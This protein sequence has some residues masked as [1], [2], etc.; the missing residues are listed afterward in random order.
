V[1]FD[2]FTP[3]FESQPDQVGKRGAG[4]VSALEDLRKVVFLD[5]DGVLNVPVVRDGKPYPPASLAELEFTPDARDATARLRERGFMLVMVTN[6][7][8]CA[9]GTQTVEAVNEINNFMKREL[10]LSAV[11]VCLHDDRDA[12]PCRKPAPGLLV[13]AAAEMGLDLKNGF[14]VGDRWKDVEA[15]HRAGCRTAFIDYKYS[16]KRPANPDCTVPTLSAAV[17]WIFQAAEQPR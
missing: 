7:P 3:G 16:E 13:Q 1:A 11:Y 5:R 10:G 4:T 14:M 8:D 17:D 12:C 15:G 2:G 9:R 6:Q